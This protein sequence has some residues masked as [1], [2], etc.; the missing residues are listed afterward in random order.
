MKCLI[1]VHPNNTSNPFIK[2]TYQHKL[3]FKKSKNLNAVQKK[4]RMSYEKKSL[5]DDSD[6]NSIS[7]SFYSLFSLIEQK[8]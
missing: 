5:K 8:V 3:L 7:K 6:K 2:P 1:L 4:V